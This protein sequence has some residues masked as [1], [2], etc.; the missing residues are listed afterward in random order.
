MR[1]VFAAGNLVHAAERADLAALSGRHA[2][3]AVHAFLQ[4]G[5]WPERRV[6][7]VCAPPFLW[8]SPSAVEPEPGGIP[9]DR[10][11]SRVGEL[12][13]AST[14]EIRQGGRV[15]WRQ[16]YRALVPARSIHTAANW[17]REVDPDGGAISFAIAP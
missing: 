7:I 17:V 13:A 2:A 16:R 6:P 12:R 8:V 14:V 4:S 3:G 9:H 10:F 5:A 1:G 11:L 15:L